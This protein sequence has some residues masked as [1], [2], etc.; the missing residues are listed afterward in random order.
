M[1][2]INGI[3]ELSNIASKL[4]VNRPKLSEQAQELSGSQEKLSDPGQKLIVNRPKLSEQ[5][6][7][8]SGSQ[9]ELSDPG[10]ELIVNRPKS[11]YPTTQKEPP[12]KHKIN[13]LSHH[14]LL[15]LLVY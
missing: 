4:I 14:I 10:Q 12:I 7:E 11:S 9:E 1:F 3:L 15:F 13:P 2:Y 6:Q 8:L 5:A